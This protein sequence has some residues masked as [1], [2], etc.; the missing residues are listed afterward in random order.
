ME[1]LYL[2]TGNIIGSNIKTNTSLWLIEDKPDKLIN[3][4]TY[5]KVN[6]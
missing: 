5:I 1:Q 4:D 2:F 3:N 6:L